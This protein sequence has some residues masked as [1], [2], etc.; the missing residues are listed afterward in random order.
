[1]SRTQTGKHSAEGQAV[2]QATLLFVLYNL[3]DPMVLTGRYGIV[4][5][6][7]LVLERC[8]M[9]K[10]TMQ[11]LW[12]ALGE[13]Q[14]NYWHSGERLCHQ[15]QRSMSHLKSSSWQASQ[16][17]QRWNMSPWE[18]KEPHGQAEFCETHCLTRLDGL[19]IRGSE[20]SRTGR[21][22]GQRE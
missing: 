1:M 20:I 19:I 14:G 5:Q 9:G 21:E 17:W 4:R 8:L 12:Q 13:S 16:S 22:Q 10:D 18:V 2:V 15:Q 6:I 7:S 3:A 11:S